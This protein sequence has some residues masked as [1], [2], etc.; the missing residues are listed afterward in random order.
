MVTIRQ[1]ENSLKDLEARQKIVP[2]DPV[3]TSY[4][5]GWKGLQAVR[6]RNSPLSEFSAAYTPGTHVLFLYV[7]PPEKMEVRDEEVKRDT[8]PPPGSI[9]VVPA[10]SSVVCSRQGSVDSSFILIR[11]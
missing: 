4:G 8:P 5:K 1:Q 11:T 7:R 10:G 6:Y 2:F 3:S 9:A